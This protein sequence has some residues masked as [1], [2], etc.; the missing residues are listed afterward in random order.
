MK[1]NVVKLRNAMAYTRLYQKY[2]YDKFLREA[3]CMDFQLE[4]KQKTHT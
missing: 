2:S 3:V 4:H 1:S